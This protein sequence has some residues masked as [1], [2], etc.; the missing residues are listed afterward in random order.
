[1]FPDRYLSHCSRGQR[2]PHSQ[3]N[4]NQYYKTLLRP[5]SFYLFLPSPVESHQLWCVQYLS[6]DVYFNGVGRR[7]KV[8]GIL[9]EIQC[10][11]VFF[12]FVLPLWIAFSHIHSFNNNPCVH[13]LCVGID[14][15]HESSLPQS[16]AF[17]L[18]R[19]HDLPRL[20]LLWLDCTGTIPREGNPLT[21]AEEHIGCGG[22][23]Y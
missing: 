3:L 20:H 8:P 18:L 13:T 15:N 22:L 21:R 16:P 1:M 11:S 17:L 5:D 6:G 23:S 4:V 12:F 19:R 9:P 10:E 14:F 2:V 7:D